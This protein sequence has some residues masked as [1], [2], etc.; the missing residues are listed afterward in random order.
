M[1]LLLMQYRL[2]P[3]ATI[4]DEIAKAIEEN[5][6][7]P[8]REL[9][10][11]MAGSMLVALTMLEW[12]GDKRWATAY[13]KQAKCM[14][15]G[16]EHVKGAGY[17]WNIDLYQNQSYLLGAVHGFSGNAFALIRGFHLHTEKQI[18]SITE[19]IMQT[20]ASTAEQDEKHA[21]W[22]PSHTSEP[23]DSKRH[24]LIHFCHGAPGMI[25]P[26]ASLPSGV[27][28]EFDQVLLKGGEL[29]WD[30]GLL[31]KGPSLCHG[32]SGNGYAFLKLHQRTGD[33]V[34]LD[35]ARIYAMHC[36]AQYHEIRSFCNDA[37]RFPLWTGD[38][39][40]AI[41]LWGCVQENADF[42]TLDVF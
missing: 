1:P 17:L 10:W 14:F 28:A 40:M 39:G 20:T 13:M 15:S 7:Q 4:A 25:I 16:M 41:F 30:A 23:R 26:L 36:I 33:K 18:E 27:N 22:W 9:M 8:V 35:R 6:S 29:I 32:T 3:S 34:W 5:N 42:P 37:P 12:T 19:R 11:G 31:E 24:P 2:R 21:N 38:P